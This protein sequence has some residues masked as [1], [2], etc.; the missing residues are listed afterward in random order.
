MVLLA[1]EKNRGVLSRYEFPAKIK[2]IF[3][4]R[5]LGCGDDGLKDDVVVVVEMVLAVMMV[6]GLVV[7]M[8]EKVVM[9]MVIAV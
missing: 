1:S 2:S 9:A 7:M 3:V 8:V 4:I 5:K 6:M